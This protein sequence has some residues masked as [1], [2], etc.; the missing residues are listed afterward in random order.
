MDAFRRRGARLG[1]TALPPDPDDRLRH[2]RRHDPHRHAAR[3]RPGTPVAAGRWRPSAGL[4][5]GTVLSLF[6][7]P[8]L[9]VWGV[10]ENPALKKCETVPIGSDVYLKLEN[11]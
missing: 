9:Y 2:H 7:L 8:M 6:Y 10:G 1:A 11:Q 5:L 4:L 3:R